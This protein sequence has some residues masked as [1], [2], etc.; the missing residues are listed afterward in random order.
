MNEDLNETTASDSTVIP[1]RE[2]ARQMAN[3]LNESNIPLIHRIITVLGR[4]RTQAF[5][6]ET[7]ELEA[8]GGAMT[9]KGD[10]RRT[11]GGVFFY[12]VRKGVTSGE[13]RQIWSPARKK[14]AARS[15]EG[16][17]PAPQ[18]AA[19][20]W[21]QV[22]ALV[23]QAKAQPGEAKTVKITLVGRPL[24]IIQQAECVILSMK[25]KE[26]GS[27]PKGLPTPPTGSAITWAVFIANK[28]WTKVAASIAKEPDDNLIVEGY[29]LLKDG[30]AVVLAQSCKSVL[31]EKAAKAQ[32]AG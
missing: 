20:T 19:L 3:A 12:R 24:K 8:Q 29:P 1:A 22:L 9:R 15:E 7:L 18:P 16:I 10:R 25:G 5:L 32:K 28:Q 30:V 6:H 11:P 4:A 23:Q 13:Q 21:D 26:P 17:P 31:L 2:V 27:L 14:S